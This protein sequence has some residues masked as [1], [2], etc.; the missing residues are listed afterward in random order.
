MSTHQQDQFGALRQQMVEQIA[1][2]ARLVGERTGRSELAKGVMSI[3]GQVPRHEFVPVE[4]RQFAYL[5]TPL[6]IGYEKTISQPFIVALMT[7]LL[8][9]DATDRVLEV[10]TGLGYQAAVLAAIA[11]RVFSVELIEELARGAQRRLND[12]GYENI[13][14]K[15]G[16]GSVGWV[17]H[18]PFDK[19]LVA[20]A[21]ELV[22]TSLL[23]QLKPGGRMV[24]PA[25]IEDAQQLMVV[26]KSAQGQLNM[27]EILPVRFSALMTSN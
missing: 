21:P 10:G 1:L 16:D 27:E 11:S 20:A 17:E 6:P 5:D 12:L 7:D 3:M 9:L 2:H 24:V 14:L 4:L 22:P 25:G 19:I 23:N 8:E 18:A 26:T 13:E 15:T